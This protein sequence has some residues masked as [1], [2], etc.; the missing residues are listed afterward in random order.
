M[1]AVGIIGLVI[2]FFSLCALCKIGTELEKTRIEN[3]ELI[4]LLNKAISSKEK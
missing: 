2:A 1:L 3:R 4:N